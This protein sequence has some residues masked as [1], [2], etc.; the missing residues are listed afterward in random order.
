MSYLDPVAA[1]SYTPLYS[2]SGYQLL[3]YA[4]ESILGASYEDI[5]LD[6]LIKPLNLTQSSLNAPNPD[7]AVIPY[8]ETVS[9]FDFE[10]GD[11]GR[12]FQIMWSLFEYS[13][14]ELLASGEYTHPQK[15]WQPSVVQFSQMP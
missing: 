10:L 15:T 3:G 14:D 2:N 13:A 5:L 4:L 8:N 9:W 6:R 1:T 7:L 11:A 12:Y